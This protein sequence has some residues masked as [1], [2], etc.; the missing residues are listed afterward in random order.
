VPD[1]IIRP[2]GQELV[3]E[4][5]LPICPEG[6]ERV[7]GQ[8][9]PITPIC[10]EGQHWDEAQGKCIPDDPCI[11]NPDLPGCDPCIENPELHECVEP[12]PDGRASNPDGTYPPTPP[13]LCEENP[14][15]M[16]ASSR[17]MSSRNH[18]DTT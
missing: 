18:R 5:C 14:A 7:D 11:E 17:I 9:V 10:P 8:C 12:C 1:D 15:R 3:D 16:S 2:E 4:Q 13:D 6:Q